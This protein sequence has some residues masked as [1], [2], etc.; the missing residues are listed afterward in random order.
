M[1]E[2]QDESTVSHMADILEGKVAP[3][4]PVAA[5]V[6]APA[7]VADPTPAPAAPATP[8]APVA[9]PDP[10]KPTPPT[11]DP[12]NTP[13]AQSASFDINAELEK[14]SGGAIKSKDEIAAILDKANKL[15]DFESKH[16]TLEQ[17]NAE[18]KAKVD[19]NP[20]ANDF[21]KK[22]NDLYKSGATET[23]IQAFTKINA[24]DDLDT[25]S[26]TDARILA[27]QVKNGLTPDEARI[28]LN[29]S[30]K[31]N[32]D[33]YDEATINAE[34]IRLK[35]DAQGDREF[36][37]THKA[38]VSAPPVD[39][40][41]KEQAELQ[42]KTTEHIAKLT[43]MVNNVLNNVAFKGL[44]LNG[45]EGAANIVADF[46]VSE[47]SKASL[48]GLVENFVQSQGMNIP[49]T[50]E[51]QKQIEQYAKNLLVIQNYQN[52]IVNAASQRELQVRAEYNNPTPVNRGQDA[53][54]PGQTSRD[55]FNQRLLESYQ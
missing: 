28:Y 4:A 33:E 10:A 9:P 42:Q 46:D 41:A 14:I 34:N 48:K 18:L 2:V 54:N 24:V 5:P 50:E 17:Q 7:P 39:N 38:E 43:P 19:A 30:Y 45:K 31:L 26:A 3:A 8:A 49:A 20:F 51:G 35:V 23:Q 55:A 27:L 16:Q 15:A 13:A 37:K 44:S 47:E 29:S 40:S 36:L 25:L 52:W 11:T 21:T 22:L 53:P 32:P 6:A 12:T 1:P